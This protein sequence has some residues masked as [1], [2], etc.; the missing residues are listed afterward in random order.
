M[1]EALPGMTS[2]WY[3]N[4]AGF[5]YSITY[6]PAMLFMGHLTDRCNRVIMVSLSC[7]IWGALSYA[8]AY[9]NDLWTLNALRLAIGFAQSFAGPP[10]YM[11]VSDF[12]EKEHRIMSFF[13]FTTLK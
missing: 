13:V 8:H 11:L 10:T 1:T 2:T 4:Y 3:G 7:M 6:A 5:F 12:F 9:T